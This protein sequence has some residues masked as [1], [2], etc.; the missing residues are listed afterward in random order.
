MDPSKKVF[1]GCLTLINF[2]DLLLKHHKDIDGFSSNT[3][4]TSMIFF[5]HIEEI[6]DFSI[7]VL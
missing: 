5:K 2:D 3:S 6:D 1:D 4:K 7:D